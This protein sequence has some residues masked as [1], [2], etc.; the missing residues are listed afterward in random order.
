MD[1]KGRSLPRSTECRPSECDTLP[2]PARCHP[3][4]RG[5]LPVGTARG[6]ADR[7]AARPGEALSLLRW[8]ACRRRRVRSDGCG[9]RRRVL[10]DRSC[11]FRLG[12]DTIDAEAGA[13]RPRPPRAA[14]APVMV[15]RQSGR[16]S[17]C[18]ASRVR[19]AWLRRSVIW[20][21]ALPP[22]FSSDPWCR[23]PQ[24]VSDTTGVRHH[25]AARAFGKTP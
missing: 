17:D 10:R 25:C 1:G 12:T 13:T 15:M 3:R 21:S 5:R 19:G 24:S 16:A 9:A 23:G 20:L 4:L 14:A 11:V 18:H 2:V 8:H 22:A 7:P 6:G